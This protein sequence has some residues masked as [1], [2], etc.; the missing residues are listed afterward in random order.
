MKNNFGKVSTP[1]PQ[2]VFSS[3]IARKDKKNLEKNIIGTNVCLKNYCLKKGLGYIENNGIKE[4]HLGKKR[5]HL[6]KKKATML[7]VKNLLR[8]FEGKE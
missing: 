7:F 2:L 4:V 6:N 8:Y 5:P 3:I 1:S